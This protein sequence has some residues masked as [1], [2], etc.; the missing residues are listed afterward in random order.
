MEILDH[1]RVGDTYEISVP[2]KKMSRNAKFRKVDGFDQLILARFIQELYFLHKKGDPPGGRF[3]CSLQGGL[4]P[5]NWRI[6]LVPA[7]PMFRKKQVEY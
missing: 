1:R 7:V 3:D 5:G 6:V 4:D 2:N